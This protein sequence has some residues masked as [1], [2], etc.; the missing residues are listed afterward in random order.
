[1][2]YPKVAIIILNWN[3]KEDDNEKPFILD[4]ICTLTSF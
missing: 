3:G 2:I 4:Y 1:M